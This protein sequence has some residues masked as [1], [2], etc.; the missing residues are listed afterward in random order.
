MGKTNQQVWQNAFYFKR[1]V[2]VPWKRAN[3]GANKSPAKVGVLEGTA[4]RA[5]QGGHR[6]DHMGKSGEC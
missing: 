3:K 2:F 1:S 6:D 4:A 5:K